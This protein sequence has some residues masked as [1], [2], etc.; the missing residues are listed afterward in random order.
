M[1]Y[2]EKLG[3]FYL[4]KENET[5]ELP[6]KRFT[7]APTLQSDVSGEEGY[8]AVFGV[9]APSTKA[10]P[11]RERPVAGPPG[12]GPPG[13]RGFVFMLGESAGESCKFLLRLDIGLFS[14]EYHLWRCFQL[15]L[16]ES[17]CIGDFTRVKSSFGDSVKRMLEIQKSYIR[18]FIL[19]M[20]YDRC[21]IHC[22][23]RQRARVD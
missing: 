21:I 17:D 20:P 11:R 7:A 18:Q 3:G 10:P 12:D 2:G 23:D 22:S 15:N 19:P 14:F 1:I 6:S 8:T 9:E 5:E 13:D 16:S 4:Q